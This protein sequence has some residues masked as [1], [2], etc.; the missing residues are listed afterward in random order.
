MT[1]PR[2]SLIRM[3][4]FLVAVRMRPG[5]EAE[6]IEEIRD[7][8]VSELRAD[9]EAVRQSLNEVTADVRKIR[10]GFGQLFGGGGSLRGLM[11]LCPMLDLLTSSL[12]RSKGN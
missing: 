6:M 5:P 11:H 3:G 2:R 10:S 12:K 9:A 8:A 4:L 1:L 7:L